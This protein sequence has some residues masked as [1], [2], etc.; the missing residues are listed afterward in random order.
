[1]YVPEILA[2]VLVIFFSH[3]R[4]MLGWYINMGSNSG[5]QAAMISDC[6]QDFF[7]F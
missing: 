2:E 5:D 6:I 7:Q 1:M 3:S 4:N